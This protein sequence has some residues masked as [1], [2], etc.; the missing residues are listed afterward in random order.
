M[1]VP[2]LGAKDAA[3]TMGGEAPP[4]LEFTRASVQ[5]GDIQIVHRQKLHTNLLTSL[6]LERD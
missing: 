3:I 6:L 1:H 5:A 4:P 2:L